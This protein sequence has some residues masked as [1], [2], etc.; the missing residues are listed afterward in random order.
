MNV[1]FLFPVPV[2]APY[3]LHLLMELSSGP[4]LRMYSSFPSLLTYMKFV[5][6]FF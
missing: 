5:E 4:S 3:F 6:S 2:L 1:F